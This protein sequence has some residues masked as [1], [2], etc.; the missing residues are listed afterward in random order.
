MTLFDDFKEHI[1]PNS[2]LISNACNDLLN[3]SNYDEIKSN[4]SVHV[5]N[6]H[7]HVYRNYL[8]KQKDAWKRITEGKIYP[9]DSGEDFDE[10]DEF[11]KALDNS[12]KSGLEKIAGFAGIAAA[13]IR[14]KKL[15]SP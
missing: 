9:V 2:K 1:P 12:A 10:L 8:D 5:K 4:C 6:L 15:C 11:F 14:L 7:D 3:G 13:S